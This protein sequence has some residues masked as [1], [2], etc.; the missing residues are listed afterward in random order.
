MRIW[1][2]TCL[3]V[4]FFT[5]HNIKERKFLQSFFISYNIL[6]YDT[7]SWSMLIQVRITHIQQHYRV[8]PRRIKRR[9]GVGFQD[10][11]EHDYH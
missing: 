7:D 9:Y 8:F 5:T 2:T 10:M 3:Y 6:V 1:D 4:Y 11:L